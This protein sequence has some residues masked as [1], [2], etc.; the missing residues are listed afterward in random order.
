MIYP[1]IL[2]EKPDY[3]LLY[4]DTNTTL[5]GA[6]AAEKANIKI[7]HVEA[8]LRSFN[9]AMPEEYNRIETDKRSTLFFCPTSTA[10]KHLQN[11]GINQNVYHIGDVMYDSAI[12]FAD[13]AKNESS[14]LA[15]LN[16][17]P[18][19]FNLATIHRAENTNDTNRLK[20]IILAFNIIATT[21]K[22]II[23]PLH[24]RTRTIIENNDELKQLIKNN[25]F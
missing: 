6:L 23:L 20:E 18:K 7:I 5:A 16:I 10:V 24:P 17:S 1:I 8:G 21:D 13:I 25:K 22:P 12:Y 19:Q 9:L 15:K 11:E 14:I 4:G 3:I 2:Q